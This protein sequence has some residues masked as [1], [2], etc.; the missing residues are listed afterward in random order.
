MCLGEAMSALLDDQPTL[1]PLLV[2][3]DSKL[4]SYVGLF[5]NGHRV[6]LPRDADRPLSDTDVLSIVP[7]VAGG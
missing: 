2:G 1:R 4:Y 3:S 7:A 5:L 6:Q